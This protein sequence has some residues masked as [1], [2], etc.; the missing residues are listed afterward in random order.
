MGIAHPMRMG[1]SNMEMSISPLCRPETL[2]PSSLKTFEHL[3]S[4]P[5]SF[6]AKVGQ[7]EDLLVHGLYTV[8]GAKSAI[9]YC[10][11]SSINY[12]QY[13]PASGAWLPPPP[14]LAAPGPPVASRGPL[15]VSSQ[16]EPQVA[17]AAP[18]LDWN[19]KTLLRCSSPDPFE[20]AIAAAELP[21]REGARVWRRGCA[22]SLVRALLFTCAR[23]PP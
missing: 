17:Y 16:A 2:R 1:S 23:L 12:E 21:A 5:T 9:G 20:L 10:T 8:R 11:S 13:L 7:I 14:E 18:L 4:R 22:Q 19:L 3:V 6:T 15:H